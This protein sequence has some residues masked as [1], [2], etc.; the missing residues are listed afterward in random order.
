MRTGGLFSILAGM[1]LILLC[2]E[3]QAQEEGEEKAPDL[4]E[5]LSG[6]DANVVLRYRFE[7]VDVA[8]FE[9][10]AYA[11]TLRTVLN[12]RTLRFKGFDLFLEAENVLSIG[13]DAYNNLGAGGLAN[14]RTDRPAV[15]DPELTQIN[16]ALVGFTG[17]RSALTLGRQQIN[18]D[19]QRFV[20]AVGWRQHHQSFNS[21]RLVSSLVPRTTFNYA[22]LDR[23]HRVNG[24]SQ[25]MSSNLLNAQVALWDGAAL[26]LY[27]Y[28]LDFDQSAAAGLS[29]ASYGS[30]LS[31]KARVGE[32]WTIL[33]EAEYAGQRDIAN[34]PDRVRAEYVH[35]LVGGRTRNVTLQ[36]AIERL[37]GDPQ[38]GQ[39]TTTLATLHAFNGWADRFVIT[40]LN[41]LQDLYARLTGKTG[42][43]SWQAWYHDF[44]ATTGSSHYGSEIDLQ[45]AYRTPWKQLFAITTA[46][47][48]ADEFATDVSRIW[49]WTAYSF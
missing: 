27:G 37:G 25:A 14:D 4:A 9:K 42:A 13:D 28:F 20:G 22:F 15:P 30:E 29:T 8:G 5:A 11:S 36:A 18:L 48:A 39:F 19:D 17:G 23:V 44:R 33:Y 38:D 12:Y 24:G 31:G 1:S 6:G 16:Q 10:N 32:D 3:A 7:F 41:G 21:F 40:P 47:Y 46:F 35:L 26:T 43:F 45:V 34:N 49:L 2:P